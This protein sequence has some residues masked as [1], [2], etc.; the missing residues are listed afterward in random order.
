VVGS[1]HFEQIATTNSEQI[2]QWRENRLKAYRGSLRHFLTA[3]CSNRL[4]EEG[5]RIYLVNST[6][7]NEGSPLD[8][9]SILRSGSSPWERTISFPGFLKVI[10]DNAS[11]DI[12]YEIELERLSIVSPIIGERQMG[13]IAVLCS[14]QRSWLRIRDGTTITITTDGAVVGSLVQL[15][16]GGYWGWDSVA[17]SLPRDFNPTKE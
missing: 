3:L 5:F 10:Y 16:A 12:Q 17:E 14:A 8:P 6:N 7:E 15:S 11:D 1:V 13:K 2:S 9:K 4:E